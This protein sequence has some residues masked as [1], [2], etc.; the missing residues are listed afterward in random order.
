MKNWIT[1]VISAL[2]LVLTFS[3]NIQAQKTD[4]QITFGSLP[5]KTYGDLPFDLVATTTSGLPVQFTSSNALVATISGNTVTIVGAGETVIT[6]SQP[7]DDNFN[8]AQQV[9][10]QLVVTKADQTITFDEL[11][12][13]TFGDGIFSLSAITTS[14]LSISFSSSNPTIASIVGNAVVINSAGECVIT[15]EQAGNKNYNSAT[16]ITRTLTINKATQFINFGTLPTKTYGD[17]PFAL[18][19][20]ATSGLVISYSSNSSIVSIV[21]NQVSILGTGEVE[22]TA[23]QTGNTNY[24]P[25]ENVRQQLTINKAQ[26]AISFTSIPTKTYGDAPFI[27]TASSS[28]RLPVNFGSQYDSLL[29]IEGNTATIVGAGIVKVYAIQSGNANYL[30]KVVEQTLVINKAPQTITFGA[31][32]I[33]KFGD[34][35]FSIS[36]TSSS[37]L[38]VSFSSN[39]KTVARVSGNTLTIVGA[40]SA[41]IVA[42]QAGNHNYLPAPNVVQSIVISAL[43]NSYPILGTTRAGGNGRGVIF[44]L[45][46]DGSNYLLQKN[47]S[48]NAYNG[49]QSGLIKGTDGKLYGMIMAGGAPSNGVVFSIQP[50]GSDYRVLHNFKFTD[51]QQPF[52]NVMEASNGYLYGMTYDGGTNNT[53]VLFR[54]KKDGSEFSKLF[55]FPN[56]GVNGYH[57]LGGLVEATN[58]DLYG[59]TAEG[60]VGAYGVLFSIKK[61][62]SGYTKLLDLTGST[63]IGGFPRGNLVQGPDQYLYGTAIQGGSSGMG[64]LFKVKTDGTGY[65]NLIEFD[66]ISRGSTPGASPIF[67]E[68]G[69]LYGTT[70]AGGTNN[71]GVIY[72]VNADGTGFNKLFDFDGTNSGSRGIGS[73]V[74]SAYGDLYG[75]TNSGGTSD[76]GVSFKIKP[77]GTGFTKLLDF[78]GTNGASPVFG[79]LLEIENGKFVGM[80]S[81]GGPSNSGIVFSITSTGSAAIVKDF[82]QPEGTPEVISSNNGNEFFG[83]A[84]SGGISGNG[85]LFKTSADGSGYEK[86]LD[87]DGNYLF[88]D[89]LI[90]TSDNLI[91]GAGREGVF[92]STNVLFRLNSDGTN[93]QRIDFANAP[94]LAVASLLEGPDQFLYGTGYITG[95][96]NGIIFKFK[97]DGS[98][99][100]K[101]ADIPGGA[102]GSQPSGNLVINN[103]ELFGLMHE[104]GANNWGAVF[105]IDIASSQY[106][107]IFSLQSSTTGSYPKKIALLNDGSLCIATAVGGSNNSGTLFSLSP[108]GSDYTKI[109]DFNTSICSNPTDIIQT[110]DGYLIGSTEYGGTS[111]NGILY[112]MLVDGSNFRKIL[113]FTGTNGSSPK[114]LFFRKATQSIAFNPIPSK[115]YNDPSFALTAT[116]SSNLPITF[117]SSD[118]SI[119]SVNGNFV[120][121][122]G[123]GE[124]TITASA[125]G[126]KNFTRTEVQRTLV[127]NKDDQVV[128]FDPIEDRVSG[129]S[130]FNLIGTATSG[131]SVEFTSTS[132][133]IAINGSTVTILSPGSVTIHANQPGNTYYSSAP[134]VQQTFCIN[135]VKPT[136]TA[137]Q[138]NFETVV[139]TSNQTIGNQWYKDGVS[140]PGENSN[141]FTA[142][143][144][145]SYTV[146]S[147]VEGCASEQADAYL[148]IIT[149]INDEAIKTSLVYPNPAIGKIVIDLSSFT[150]ITPIEIQIFDINGRE[151]DHFNANG[152]TEVDLDINSLNKGVY[153]LKVSSDRSIITTRFVKK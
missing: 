19:G 27:L 118:Q 13:K 23:S 105:K 60:G 79:N 12:V 90:Q 75:M 81:R 67:G 51:G 93:F 127:I 82:P 11:P 106:S 28:S 42:S 135:P 115:Q 94:K 35:P 128:Y 99:F 71:F 54:I 15:A 21:G 10:Q 26:Q 52:G 103:G 88:V 83:V 77:D 3:L 108:D 62:G 73:L 101:L 121:I 48:P 153:I 111:N 36:G 68:D 141:S 120:T 17:A 74:Q 45:N 137:T 136:I 33:K 145:G 34:S 38:P 43:G 53:G 46:S 44:N 70:Q 18:S 56:A 25:A 41:S 138:V 126:N 125:S 124:V 98:C 139:L 142:S 58:G 84:S 109:Y 147:T 8:P 65:T 78:D 55:E 5:A 61:D 76:L 64:V 7:G 1:W 149:G 72:S 100:T 29:T 49:P 57:P 39:R 59:M 114:Q 122:H 152:Q 66:G 22:I 2:A 97:T 40:G 112:E 87:L 37:G 30:P 24:L 113:E 129:S 69:K 96:P 9:Q 148:M 146:V 131:L 95:A 119:A 89:K 31:L 132:D 16:P 20:N 50:D 116:N 144:N 102:L 134:Q 63:T 104:G 130:A 85:A 47:F 92:T 80:T 133:H 4:Q 117:I 86:I 150:H 123:V 14:N 107:C 143:E 6:A 32:P 151:I 91:W 110:I 140:I